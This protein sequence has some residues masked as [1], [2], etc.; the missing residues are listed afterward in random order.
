MSPSTH[1]NVDE[2][3][4]V[5]EE[6]TKMGFQVTTNNDFLTAELSDYHDMTTELPVPTN[7]MKVRMDKIIDRIQ[8]NLKRLQILSDRL[9]LKSQLKGR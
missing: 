1:P 8:K 7:V 9:T 3:D 4:E 6:T 5:Y 2:T